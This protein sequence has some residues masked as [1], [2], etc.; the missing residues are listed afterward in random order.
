[1]KTA[2]QF[3][4]DHIGKEYDIDNSYGP[5]CVDAF[6]LFTLEEYGFC[7]YNC[8]NGWASGL[9]IYRKEKPYYP[10]FIE[11]DK[12]NM[13]TGDWVF[14]NNGSKDCPDS[15]VAM[16]YEG[17]FFSQNQNGHRYFTLADISLDGVLGVLRPKIFENEYTLGNYRTLYNMNVRR[18]ASINTK[19]KK[20]SELT[21]DGKRNATSNN[22]ND[23]AVY[24]KGTIF[25]AKEI[26]EN[27]NSIWAKSP[28]GYICLK[29]SNQVYCEKVE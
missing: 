8:G 17:K 3:Y 11:V 15:H 12:N 20:V 24:K 6:K 4:E 2:K 10:Y 7:N 27:N 13:Q 9:W 21:E 5:Q 28:S 14:W 22:P 18:G 25:T 23:N 1:M 29:D 19:I 16:Y 26:I